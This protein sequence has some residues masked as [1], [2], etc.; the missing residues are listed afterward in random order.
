MKKLLVLAL[1]TGCYATTTTTISTTGRELQRLE[2]GPAKALVL[3]VERHD[4]ALVVSASWPRRCKARIVDH[5]TVSKETTA[6]LAGTHDGETWGYGLLAAMIVVY[7]VGIADALITGGML[8]GGGDN[9]TTEE[10][11]VHDDVET[12][13]DIPAAHV[14][15]QLVLASGGVIDGVTDDRG[16]VVYMLAS[17]SERFQVRAGN[18]EQVM[19]DLEVPFRR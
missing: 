8:I 11:H 18:A 14:A 17:A 15:I 16:E 9:S 1:V 10:T 5:A 2:P 19:P 3:A 12:S 4:T 13:C 6:R 7:P